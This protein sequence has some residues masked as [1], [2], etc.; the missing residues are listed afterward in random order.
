MEGGDLALHY[1]NCPG[2][3]V[4][5]GAENSPKGAERWMDFSSGGLHHRL[6]RPSLKSYRLPLSNRVDVQQTNAPESPRVYTQN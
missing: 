5:F 4:I 2:G 1:L 3:F 6:K